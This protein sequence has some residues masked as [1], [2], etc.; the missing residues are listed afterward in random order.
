M[1]NKSLFSP[2]SPRFKGRDP[3]VLSVCV[4]RVICRRYGLPRGEPLRKRLLKGKFPPDEERLQL[5]FL[6]DNEFMIVITF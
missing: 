5:G 3:V 4:D 2:L 1:N 6:L